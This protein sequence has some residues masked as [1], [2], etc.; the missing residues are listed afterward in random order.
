MEWYINKKTNFKYKLS[1]CLLIKNETENLNDWIEHYINEGVEHFFITSNN[2]TD[3]I[4]NFILN[5]EYKNMITLITDNSDID[6]Y[7]DQVKHREILCKNFY[8]IIKNSTEWC[9]LVDIDEFMYGKM[10]IS[11]QVLLIHLMK[12]LVVFMFIGIFLNQRL[13][14]KIT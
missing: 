14:L 13:I 4:D 9:I 1:A 12:I 10:V 6:I 2:S 8:N 5:S 7:N 3:G 11:F